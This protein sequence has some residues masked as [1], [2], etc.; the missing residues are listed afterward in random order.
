MSIF[1]SWSHTLFVVHTWGSCNLCIRW[2]FDPPTSKRKCPYDFLWLFHSSN[3]YW[4]G[5]VYVFCFCFMSE[6]MRRLNRQTEWFWFLIK[7]N[8]AVQE[9]WASDHDRMDKRSTKPHHRF[10]YQCLS[11]VKKLDQ[12][13]PCRAR[14]MSS[15]GQNDAKLS[16]V[17]CIIS[18]TSSWTMLK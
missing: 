11:N 10:A 18:H 2:G 6:S 8:H 1:T 13:I 3:Q 16:L 4:A 12:N 15:T 17:I 7:I 5:R 14:V 9:L